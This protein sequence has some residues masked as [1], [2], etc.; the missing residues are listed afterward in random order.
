MITL[1]SGVCIHHDTKS[2][3][4]LLAEAELPGVKKNDAKVDVN[5]EGSCFYNFPYEKAVNLP[6]EASHNGHLSGAS[7]SSVYPQTSQT[8]IL[9]SVTSFLISSVKIFY[10][11]GHDE[12]IIA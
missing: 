3:R 9:P 2:D 10:Y 12:I 7:P 4:L 11:P 1:M 5:E 8:W 6:F